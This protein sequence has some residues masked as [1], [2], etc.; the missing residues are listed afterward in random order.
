MSGKDPSALGARSVV[1]YT[2]TLDHADQRWTATIYAFE[3][4][5]DGDT[6]DTGSLRREFGPFD[7]HV[8]VAQ[9]L[10]QQVH[11]HTKSMR[12]EVIGPPTDP[13][14]GRTAPDSK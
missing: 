8:T 2:V 7:D 14:Q 10:C 4:T 1:S 6:V 3:R 12:S 9:W 5:A 11:A 13:P